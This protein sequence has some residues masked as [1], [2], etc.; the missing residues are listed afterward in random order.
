MLFPRTDSSATSVTEFVCSGVPFVTASSQLF[1][2]VEHR[3]PLRRSALCNF[4]GDVGWRGW[5]DLSRAEV[6]LQPMAERQ[7]A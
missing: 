3:H 2:C 4:C 5:R 6:V 1:C 7:C